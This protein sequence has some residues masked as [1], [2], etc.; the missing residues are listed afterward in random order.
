MV[1]ALIIENAQPI[2]Q[3]IKKI[4]GFLFSAASLFI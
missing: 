2:I 1:E 3:Y 4:Y